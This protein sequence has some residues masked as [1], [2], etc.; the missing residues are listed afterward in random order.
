MQAYEKVISNSELKFSDDCGVFIHVFPKSRIGVV[1]GSESNIKITYP[2]DLIIAEQI[3]KEGLHFNSTKT[4]IYP[5]EIELIL[6]E[7]EG[8]NESAV[9]GCP[10]D[11][12]GEAVVAILISTK[13]KN[14]ISDD[15][16]EEILLKSLAKFKCPARYIWLNE[17][18][19]NAMGKVQK[20]VLKEKYKKIFKEIK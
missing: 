14:I 16:I 6:D 12:L 2:F 15:S 10:H 13:S 19:R 17:L 3:I 5:K 11:D 9:I 20:K 7:I 4:N 8:I 18:P 1:K